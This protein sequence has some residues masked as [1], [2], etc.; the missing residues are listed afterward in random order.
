[1]I[2][3]AQS[4]QLDFGDGSALNL[5]ITKAGIEA[6]NSEPATPNEQQVLPLLLME[7]AHIKTDHRSIRSLMAESLH[8]VWTYYKLA[9]KIDEFCLGCKIDTSRSA[10]RQHIGTPAPMIPSK[11]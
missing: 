1:M 8:Q 9:P 10:A 6:N 4:N 5:P 7:L 3:S 11:F 2:T